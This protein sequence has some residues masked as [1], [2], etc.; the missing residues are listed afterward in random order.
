L[1]NKQKKITE[2]RTTCK[3][4]KEAKNP[5]EGKNKNTKKVNKDN[6]RREK[7]NN[8]NTSFSLTFDRKKN[9]CK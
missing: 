6:R 9:Q 8:W 4:Y 3:I 5:G 1:Y 2:E 7:I